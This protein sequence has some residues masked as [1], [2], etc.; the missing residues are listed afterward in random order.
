ML[1]AW[2]TQTFSS[3]PAYTSHAEIST[4]LLT[5]SAVYVDFRMKTLASLAIVSVLKSPHFSEGIIPYT[6][7]RT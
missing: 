3:P 5:L 2:G 1:G 4:L 6:H 7:P